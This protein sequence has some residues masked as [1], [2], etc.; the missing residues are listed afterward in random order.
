MPVAWRPLAA[1]AAASMAVQL[2]SA[3]AG[4]Y[5]YFIDELYYLD[6]ARHPAWGYI[7]HPPLAVWLLGLVMKTLGSSLLAIRVVPSLLGAAAILLAG[8]LSARMGA[9]ASGQILAGLL[10][11]LHPVLLVFFGVYTTNAVDIVLWILALSLLLELEMGAGPRTW[12]ALGATLGLAQLTKHPSFV[13]ALAM[14][15][16]TLAT[17]LRRQLRGRWPWWGAA[18]AVTLILPNV[19]WEMAH[20]WLTLEFVRNAVLHKNVPL[21]PLAVLGQQIQFNNPGTLLF[22]L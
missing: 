18:I 4:S 9:P 7:D 15:I 11:W 12:L 19:F 2:I 20:D 3:A 1:I 5:G 14:G 22:W 16:A 6:C 13:L 8:R 21:G 17:P 10:T